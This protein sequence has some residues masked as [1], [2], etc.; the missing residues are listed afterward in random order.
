MKKWYLGFLMALLAISLVMV[1]C[2]STTST[3]TSTPA[4]STTTQTSST[5]PVASTTPKASVKA[6]KLV[7]SNWMQP[8]TIAKYSSM[9]DTW[10]SEFKDKTGGRYDVEVVHGG[11]LTSVADSYD[12]VING[13][14]DMAQVIPQD[15]ERPFP[16][17]EVVA[18][19]WYQ[20]R[21]DTATKALY[22]LR[23]KG[24]FDKEF[25]DVKICLMNIG[26]S[27][28]DLFTIKPVTSLKDLQGMKLATG[29]GSRIDVV[30]GLGAVPVF[31]PPPEVYSML[32][33]GVVDGIM[34]T[35]YS[36]YTDNTAD[37]LTTLVNPVRLFRISHVLCMNK[38][39]YNKM[40][41][42][43]KKIVDEMDANARMSL[44]G[45]KILADQYD[46]SIAKFLGSTGH[47]V[48]LS[49]EDTTKLESICHDIFE[50]WIAEKE[51]AGLPGRQ[52]VNDYYNALVSLGDTNPA[53]G[54]KP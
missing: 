31:C 2:S 35:G 39:V 42:D 18:L 45:A 40:P 50:K 44:T 1:G 28:D 38:E 20:V 19:P 11:A 32:Q 30:K 8:P 53:C 25:A 22:V 34:M 14:A 51:A 52:I 5:S 27:S 4:A 24:Y 7:L 10:A 17:M 29:G 48:T 41:A 3:T 49:A 33:K 37:Y 47:A 36:L 23:E 21:A 15:T 6:T 12:G 13:I 9:F 26:A 54:Y 43:V 16:M 46:E